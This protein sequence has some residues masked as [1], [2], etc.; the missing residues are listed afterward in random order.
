MQDGL[1]PLPELNCRQQNW[2]DV[3]HWVEPQLTTP[4]PLDGL[5]VGPTSAQQ[6][7]EFTHCSSQ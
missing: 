1:K 4:G 2:L 7:P 6:S 5:Q 3:L